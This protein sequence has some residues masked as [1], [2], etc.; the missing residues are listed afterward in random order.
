MEMVTNQYR[1]I[2]SH[3][4]LNFSYI[5]WVLNKRVRSISSNMFQSNTN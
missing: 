4:M 5:N 1:A 3:A 2:R